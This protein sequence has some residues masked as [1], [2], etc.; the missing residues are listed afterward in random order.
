[1]P[2]PGKHWWRGIGRRVE[3]WEATA[4][5]QPPLARSTAVFLDDFVN[6]KKKIQKRNNSQFNSYQFI[7]KIETTLRLIMF[8]SYRFISN[9]VVCFPH[10]SAFFSWFNDFQ[11]KQL[12]TGTR[13]PM[14]SGTAWRWPWCWWWPRWDMEPLI[15]HIFGT[16][17]LGGSLKLSGW[18]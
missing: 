10:N 13:A 12:A 7:S 8:N 3:R 9:W 4:A 11:V 15:F 1:M 14:T 17:F 2:W 6:G 5:H 16:F 18:D